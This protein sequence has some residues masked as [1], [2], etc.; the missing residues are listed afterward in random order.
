MRREKLPAGR[1]EDPLTGAAQAA[2]VESGSGYEV[3][4]VTG[5]EAEDFL[6]RILTAEIPEVAGGRS[7]LAGLCNPKGRLLALARVVPWED[8]YRLT[9]PEDVANDTVARLRMYVL[10][11][12]VT[13]Q[14]P[15]EPQWRLVRAAGPQARAVLGAH[16]DGPLPEMDDGVL[17]AARVAIIRLPGMP[18]R[19]AVMGPA[20]AI[21]H[22]ETALAE[23]LPRTDAEGWQALEI[24]AG[25]PEIRST[26][27]ELFIPQMV[28]LDRLGGV[29]FSKGCFPG[30]EVV[31][32]AHYRGKVKQRMFQA[33]GPG[34][35]P[36]R[37]SEIRDAEEQLA[38]HIVCAARVP[39]GFIALASLREA[40]LGSAPLQVNGQPL[41][42]G[43]TT[44]EPAG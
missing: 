19:Y 31:A 11:S 30:Q 3:V 39:G 6:K 23:E 10:R 27:R 41:E 1:L 43:E 29:S 25:Q 15:D 12:K 38:G 35:A 14:V 21:T 8:G 13:V 28:N 7:V 24:G 16:V 36:E 18:E 40:Q 32:R 37:G 4:A 33:Y 44:P 17:R 5:A 2:C 26:T 22:L 34:D 42:L 20:D 9:L